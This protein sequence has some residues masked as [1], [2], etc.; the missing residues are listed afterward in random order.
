VTEKRL[1]SPPDSTSVAYPTTVY[2]WPLSV[3]RVPDVFTK[4]VAAGGA[5]VGDVPGVVVGCVGVGVGVGDGAG[6][7]VAPGRHCE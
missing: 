2:F 1:A 4:P 5:E 3:K 7:E 6:D